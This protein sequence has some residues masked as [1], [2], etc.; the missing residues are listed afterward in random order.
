MPYQAGKMESLH[1]LIHGEG[2][3]SLVNNFLRFM[4][5]R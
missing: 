3:R 4:P 1:T 5:P 2:R